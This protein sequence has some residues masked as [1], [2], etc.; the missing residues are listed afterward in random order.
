ME[1]IAEGWLFWQAEAA[2]LKALID[3]KAGQS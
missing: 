3:V 1:F 2:R